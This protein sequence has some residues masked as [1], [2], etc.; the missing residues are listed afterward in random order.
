M[1]YVCSEPVGAA[2]GGTAVIRGAIPKKRGGQV[3]TDPRSRSIL[4]NR[5]VGSVSL[6]QGGSLGIPI[7]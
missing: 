4:V 7:F 5:V 6:L 3:A 2:M 1:T